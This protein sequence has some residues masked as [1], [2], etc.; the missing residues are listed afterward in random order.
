M[1]IDLEKYGELKKEVDLKKYNTYHIG[2]IA[3]YLISPKSIPDLKELIKELKEKNIA[4]IILGNGSNVVLNDEYFDGVIIN[5]KNISSYVINPDNTIYAEAGAMLSK[6]SLDSIEHSLKGLEFAV[7]IPGTI[8][9]SI[10]GN[11]GA[12]NSCLLD[13]IGEVTI[14]NENNEIETLPHDDISYSYRNTM[15]KE[16]KNCIIVSA[17]IFLSHGDKAAS[18]EIVADRK[19]RRLESQ[20]LEYPSAGSVFRNP[21]GDFAGRLIEACGLKVHLLFLYRK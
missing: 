3:K 17:K 12:Y 5:F 20:P 6:V 11:A 9:G 8:G 7:G 18:Q 1:N 14:I 15:F 4:Y 2:G 10:V 19:R 21:E 16:N 13:Y